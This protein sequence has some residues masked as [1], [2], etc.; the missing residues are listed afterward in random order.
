MT[1]ENFIKFA[2]ANGGAAV[3]VV[4]MYV[5]IGKLETRL[6]RVEG[7]LTDCY[8]LNKGRDLS[9]ENVTF[10]PQLAILTDN[11][12]KRWKRKS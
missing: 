6:D 3:A 8:Q 4:L 5:Y 12:S 7:Q 11:K 9:D 1:V 10:N 2:K